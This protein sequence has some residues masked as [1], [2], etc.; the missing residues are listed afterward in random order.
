MRNKLTIILIIGIFFRLLAAFS[1]YHPDIGYLDF[2][3]QVLRQ[4]HFL[5]LY[6]YL[7]SLDDSDPI[8]K[9]FPKFAFNYP[10]LVYF[11]VGGAMTIFSGFTDPLFHND[12]IFDYSSVLGDIRL[13]F[14]LL[15]LKLPYLLFD[16]PIAFLLMGIFKEKKDRL[17]AFAFWMFNPVVIYATY[18]MGQFDIVPTFFVIASIYA[19]TKAGKNK[20]IIAA[21]LLGIGAA[22][23]I[24]PLL[25]L[26]PLVAL[27]PSWLERVKLVFFGLAPYIISILPFLHSSGFRSTALVANQ[28]T[29]SFYAQI[30][31]S[32][33]ESIILYLAL[34]SF[35][36]FLFLYKSALADVL[37]QRYLIILL[38]FF[39]FTHYHMQ[40]FLWLT[41]FFIIELVVNRFKHLLLVAVSFISFL[42]LIF[43]YEPSLSIGLFSPIWRELY[44][45]PSVWIFLGK[46]IDY[47]F[48]RSLLQSMFAA[49]AFYFIYYYLSRHESRA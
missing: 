42:G 30:P 39:V 33:G 41:P 28:T 37:W 29:K 38:L 2:S 19:L 4:G 35:F 46:N 32:G 22:F 49:A 34:V 1:G 16:I 26:I 14:L 12:F 23:K 5:D 7:Y 11:I 24:Y 44:N 43:F 6:D 10:P 9:S 31:V 25:L 18:L 13:N 17:I 3:G 8:L 45:A 21:L 15:S 20:F 48:S 47:N 40:W 36:Y 27:R